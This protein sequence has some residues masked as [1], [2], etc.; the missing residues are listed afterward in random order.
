MASHRTS[1]MKSLVCVSIV[2]AMLLLADVTAANNQHLSPDAVA[3][4]SPSKCPNLSFFVGSQICAFTVK[5]RESGSQLVVRS[6]TYLISNQLHLDDK[7]NVACCLDLVLILLVLMVSVSFDTA[8]GCK[9]NICLALLLG[10][11]LT[12]QAY[13]RGNT[14][15][16]FIDLVFISCDFLK[17]FS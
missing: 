9:T 5:F 13:L 12:Q 10:S 6:A 2:L 8:C 17:C 11:G 1:L 7:H 3:G 16:V 4:N 14:V 15:S